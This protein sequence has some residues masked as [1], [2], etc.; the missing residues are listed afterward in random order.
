[1]AA[2]HPN[3]PHHP[4][5]GGKQGC[6][7]WK[8]VRCATATVIIVVP[9]V[10]DAQILMSMLVLVRAEIGFNMME[11]IVLTQLDNQKV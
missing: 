7:V 6:A 9:K 4:C 5:A 2:F 8:V 3:H 10:S 1:M 11:C